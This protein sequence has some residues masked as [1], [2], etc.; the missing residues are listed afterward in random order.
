MFVGYQFKYNGICA[1]TTGMPDISSHVV[2]STEACYSLCQMTN[3]CKYFSMIQLN[4][5]VTWCRLH[6]S[7]ITRGTTLG[8]GTARCYAMPASQKTGKHQIFFF[9]GFWS[10]FS[11]IYRYLI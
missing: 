4:T 3:N 5:G 11:V 7:S 9:F 6:P 1:A 8:D 10:H 2:E